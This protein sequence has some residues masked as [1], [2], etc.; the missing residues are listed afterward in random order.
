MKTA[1]RRALR[2]HARPAQQQIASFSNKIP[3]HQIPPPISEVFFLRSPKVPEI[4]HELNRRG[5]KQADYK[6]S[7]RIIAHAVS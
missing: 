3:A 5:F 7:E 1:S 4:K 2:L 6:V